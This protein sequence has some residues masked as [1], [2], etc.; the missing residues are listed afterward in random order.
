MLWFNH[1]QK[2]TMKLEEKDLI[3]KLEGVPLIV[4]QEAYD[5]M[6]RQGNKSQVFEMERSWGRSPM[7]ILQ[8]NGFLAIDWFISEQGANPWLLASAGKYALILEW[9]EQNRK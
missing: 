6:M 2:K 9:I 5:E 3:G 1:K 7:K 4:A 8:S